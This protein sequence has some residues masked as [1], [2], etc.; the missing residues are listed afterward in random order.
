[1][2]E[3]VETDCL[4]RIGPQEIVTMRGKIIW[5][6]LILWGVAVAL[7]LWMIPAEPQLRGDE[8]DYHAFA[9]SLEEGRGY[10][11]EE[12]TY[13]RPP[14]YPMF[15]ASVYRLFGRGNLKAVYVIQ[16]LLGAL[17][18]NL[19]YEMARRPFGSAVALLASVL[20]LVN[21]PS[22]ATST[23]LL[24]ECLFTLCFLGAF[25]SLQKGTQTDI[26]FSGFFFG[27]ATLI[28]GMTFLLPFVAA[29][30]LIFLHGRKGF[31]KG[32]VLLGIFLLCLL[33]LAIRNFYVHRTFVPV[34]TQGGYAFYSAYHPVDGKVFGVNVKDER[35]AFARQLG[36]ETEMSA[37]L[38]QKTI[39]DIRESPAS[40]IRLELLKFLYFWAPFDWEILGDGRYHIL[41]GFIFPFFLLGLFL[42][43]GK[44]LFFLVPILYFQGM[45]LLFYGSPRFRLPIEP[46]IVIL[47]AFG[48]LE[49]FQKLPRRSMGWAIVSV[50]LVI[51]A[52]LAAFSEPFKR[53]LASSLH[54]TGIW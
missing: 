22:I 21:F 51:H 11:S 17:V 7:R 45:A 30:Y 26:V 36:S 18:C 27:I 29:G 33:P 49:L 14:L 9:V 28:K 24:T 41:Y 20:M 4:S 23:L 35:T 32:M 42:A 46:F 13:T 19:V 48:L 10:R 47:G 50:F 25:F 37:Y 40:L 54:I 3:Y 39:E 15:V 43:K 2:V 31:K 44:R 34:S 12:Q 8:S 6:H 38:F 5:F 53:L 1:M 16:A 52:T